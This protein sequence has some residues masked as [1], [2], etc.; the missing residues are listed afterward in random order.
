MCCLQ[1][2]GDEEKHEKGV[3]HKEMLR[4]IEREE[5]EDV[6]DRMMVKSRRDMKFKRA[7]R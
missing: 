4:V 6:G 3:T 2:G 7:N 5:S 1:E